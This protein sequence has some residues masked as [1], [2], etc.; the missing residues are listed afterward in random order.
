M[1]QGSLFMG[2]ELDINIIYIYTVLTLYNCNNHGHVIKQLSGHHWEPSG[3]IP[4][5]APSRPQGLRDRCLRA[6]PRQPGQLPAI[7]SDF[8]CEDFRGDLL[9]AN[10]I[11]LDFMGIFGL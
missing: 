7:L 4:A 8:F 5:P 10:G 2:I 1:G 6:P 3:A 9:E 11:C